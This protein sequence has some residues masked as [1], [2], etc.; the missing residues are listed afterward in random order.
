MSAEPA[1]EP[2]T[3]RRRPLGLELALVIVVALAVN[4]PG[5]WSY[6]LVDPWETHYGE[7]GRMMLQDHDWVH[8]QWP[9]GMSPDDNEGFRSKPVLTFWMIAAG[10][11]AVGLASD[12]GYSGEMEH[13]ARTMIAMFQAWIPSRGLSCSKGFLDS[14]PSNPV[15]GA[16]GTREN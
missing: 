14:S 16:R 4:V 12:G 11:R 5:I 6:S 13:D 9:G 1:L 2:A 10:M 15:A 7:V 8:L 3:P